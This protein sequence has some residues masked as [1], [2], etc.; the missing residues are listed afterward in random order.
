MAKEYKTDTTQ[1]SCSRSVFK[2]RFHPPKVLQPSALGRAHSTGRACACTL[3]TCRHGPVAQHTRNRRITH[4]APPRRMAPTRLQ[5]QHSSRYRCGCPRGQKVPTTRS[6]RA[7][8]A[9]RLLRSQRSRRASRPLQPLDH[10]LRRAARGKA[11][12][13]LHRGQAA[14]AASASVWRAVLLAWPPMTLGTG[15]PSAS[16]TA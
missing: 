7:R 12:A 4:S 16:S 3:T 13:A 10:R 15:R 9:K 8:S 11:A 6:Q 14:S 2:V 5:Q 1:R